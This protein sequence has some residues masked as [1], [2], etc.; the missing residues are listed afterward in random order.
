MKENDSGRVP[1]SNVIRDLKAAGLFYSSGCKHLVEVRDVIPSAAGCEDCLKM[2]D[3]WVHLRLCLTCG[4]VGCC[5]DS[6]NTHATRH[7]H[8][9]NHPMIV[10]YEEDEE[11]LWCYADEVLFHI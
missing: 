10:S 5:D 4:Y 6:K 2:G 8:A 11:W 1:V 9:A 7:H 3:S